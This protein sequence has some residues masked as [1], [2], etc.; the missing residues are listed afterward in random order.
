[1]NRLAIF[2]I[3]LTA[4][5]ALNLIGIAW[6]RPLGFA[7]LVFATFFSSF[8]R[9]VVVGLLCLLFAG[10]AVSS[11]LGWAAWQMLLDQNLRC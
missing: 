2:S 1:M 11:W 4:G 7:L 10:L 9:K 5:V 3:L 6:L 8:P